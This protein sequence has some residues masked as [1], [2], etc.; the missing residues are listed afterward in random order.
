[1]AGTIL[2][3]ED[4]DDCREMLA[5]VFTRVGYSILQ[6]SNGL[7]AIEKAVIGRPDLILMD[8]RMPKLD[9]F[10]AAER[11][12][13]NPV[14][15]DIPV[16]ICTATR[17]EALECASLAHHVVEIVQKPVKIQELRDVVQ[18]YVPLTEQG[19]GCTRVRD[20]SEPHVEVEP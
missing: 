14:T 17:K 4:N 2:I 9:G 15:K 1:M 13:K 8:L 18:K 19:S 6:A 12:K 3:A 20:L 7:E 5:L 10:G 11:L 16:V